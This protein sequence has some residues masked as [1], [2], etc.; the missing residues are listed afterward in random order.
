MPL[1]QKDN[2]TGNLTCEPTSITPP[3][4]RPMSMSV[5]R[6]RRIRSEATIRTTHCRTLPPMSRGHGV[7]RSCHDA[8]PR[9]IPP[10]PENRPPHIGHQCRRSVR[11]SRKSRARAAERVGYRRRPTTCAARGERPG[12]CSQHAQLRS[13][14]REGVGE[15]TLPSHPTGAHCEPGGR[16]CSNRHR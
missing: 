5:R 3:D 2:G 6:L 8:E 9:C 13:P 15:R 10:R 16:R 11:A 12:R 7:C 14:V 4:V 1:W